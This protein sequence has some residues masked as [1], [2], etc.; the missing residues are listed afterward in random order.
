MG[1]RLGYNIYFSFF[2]FLLGLKSSPPF[3]GA[4][5]LTRRIHLLSYRR[6]RPRHWNRPDWFW[7]PHHL[8]A[9]TGWLSAEEERRGDGSGPLGVKIGPVPCSGGGVGHVCGTRPLALLLRIRDG[10]RRPHRLPGKLGF[11]LLK[12]FAFDPLV[13]SR[14]G[15]KLAKFLAKLGLSWSILGEPEDNL[16]MVSW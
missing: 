6:R 13:C 15:A 8:S 9:R 14:S 12:T 1:S 3:C 16:C 4:F 10:P 5:R 11:L 2:S 7:A